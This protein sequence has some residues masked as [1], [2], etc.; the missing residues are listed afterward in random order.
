MGLVYE[1]VTREITKPRTYCADWTRRRTNC[2]GVKSMEQIIM[3]YLY[4]RE[5]EAVVLINVPKY[6]MKAT[7]STCAKRGRHSYRS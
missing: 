4:D 5:S 2:K 3:T 1:E 6:I 7:A